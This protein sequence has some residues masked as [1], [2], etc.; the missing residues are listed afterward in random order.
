VFDPQ[1]K[2]SQK[3]GTPYYIAPEVLKKSYTEKCDLWSVGVIMYILLCG[4]PPFNGS[5]DEQIIKAV[6]AGKYSLDEPEWADVSAEAK[7]LVAKLLTY[8]PDERPSASEALKHPW[9][10]KYA[11]TDKVDRGLAK[12]T[13]QNL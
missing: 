12:K 5:R 8:N 4:Y 7:D 3:F 13:L 9:I 2:M 10:T 1:K 6:L 11:E